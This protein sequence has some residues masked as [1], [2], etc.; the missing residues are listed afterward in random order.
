MN[1]FLIGYDLHRPGQN[2]PELFAVIQKFPAWWHRLDSTWIVKSDLGVVEIRDLLMDH[3]D[4]TDALLVV[5]LAGP[6][7]WVGFTDDAGQWLLDHLK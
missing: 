6:A 1:T 7:A 3:T 2:Y 5:E 4:S